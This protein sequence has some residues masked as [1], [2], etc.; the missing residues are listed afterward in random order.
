MK[1]QLGIKVLRPGPNGNAAAGA[2]NAANYDPAIANPYPDLPDV[3]T[4]KN[5]QKVTSAAMWTNQRRPEIIE[6]FEREV[7]GRVPKNVPKVTWTTAETVQATVANIPVTGKRL[8]GR[9]DNSSYPA[10]N[11][12]IQMILVTP[13]SAQKKVPILMMFGGG[14][15]PG[16]PAA[17]GKA[18]K[19]DFV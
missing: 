18:A 7:L 16:S 14:A 5:G 17:A 2:P 4:L 11:V 8:I 6:D 12:E 1:D 3:L 9:V 19:A 13:T 10:I 15:L